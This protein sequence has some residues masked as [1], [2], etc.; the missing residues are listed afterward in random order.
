[1]TVEHKPYFSTRPHICTSL[2]TMYVTKLIGIFVIKRRGRY[3]AFANW[4]SRTNIILL[5][6]VI[7]SNLRSHYFF[8]RAFYK[9]VLLYI[10]W[11]R[12]V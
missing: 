4:K 12:G 11:I 8:K 3:R 1:M 10:T 7:Q 2:G 6:L 9:H 5:L